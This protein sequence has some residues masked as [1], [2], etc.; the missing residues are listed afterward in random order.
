MRNLLPP[1]AVN[2]SGGYLRAHLFHAAAMYVIQ[3]KD[4]QIYVDLIKL[5]ALRSKSAERTG[6]KNA[7]RTA[8]KSGAVRKR[9]INNGEYKLCNQC[10]DQLLCG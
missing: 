3:V 7:M 6:G 9:R 4:K 10:D 2:I 8:G 1:V 5:I